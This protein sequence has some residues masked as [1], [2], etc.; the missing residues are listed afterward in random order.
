MALYFVTA[1]GM[2]AVL[3]GIIIVRRVRQVSRAER[4]AARAK[5]HIE[6]LQIWNDRGTDDPR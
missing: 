3:V 6:E 5:R 2:I 1:I 4:H